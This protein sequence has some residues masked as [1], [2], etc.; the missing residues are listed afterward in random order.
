TSDARWPR[1]G[2]ERLRSSPSTAARA[3]PIVTRQ[4]STSARSTRHVRWQTTGRYTA[5]GP[6]VRRSYA[7]ATRRDR[8]PTTEEHPS[9]H[10][11][12]ALLLAER[13]TRDLVALTAR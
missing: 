3:P 10:R 2:A 9:N 8:V 13:L 6:L 12:T 5:S 1:G 7:A 11:G 4:D